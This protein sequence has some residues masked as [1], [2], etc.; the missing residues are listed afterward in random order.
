VR[1]RFGFEPAQ[2]RIPAKKITHS[3]LKKISSPRSG[4]GK[5]I[6]EQV[7]VMG[8]GKTFTARKDIQH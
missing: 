5:S 2:L 7:I 1:N 3:E 4:A 6:V 8:Q